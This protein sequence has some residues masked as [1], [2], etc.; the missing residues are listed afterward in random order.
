MSKRNTGVITPHYTPAYVSV[1]EW[2]GINVNDAVLVK[3]ERGTY[4]FKEAH[5]KDGEVIAVGVIGGPSGR[6]Q[7][8]YFTPD[9]VSK[10]KE[11]RRRKPKFAGDE[12]ADDEAVEE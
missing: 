12:I 5:V 8:R 2:N 9:R 3:N 7:F 1:V 4:V 11:K 10:V 6:S